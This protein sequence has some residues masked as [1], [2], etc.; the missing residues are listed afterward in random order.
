MWRITYYA[1]VEGDWTTEP[2]DGDYPTLDAAHAA[3]DAA[4]RGEDEM[5]N[6]A[7]PHFWKEEDVPD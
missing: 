7:Y 6:S 1:D 3:W 2:L 5:G 4:Y